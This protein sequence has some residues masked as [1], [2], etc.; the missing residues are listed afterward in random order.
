MTTIPPIDTP[1]ELSLGEAQDWADLLKRLIEAG[2][3]PSMIA[4]C[5]HIRLGDM[6]GAG[7]WEAEIGNQEEAC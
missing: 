2:I 3:S 4:A 7:R 6:P 5:F 1:R